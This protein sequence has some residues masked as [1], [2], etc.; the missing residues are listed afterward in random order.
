MPF[1][2]KRFAR[3]LLTLTL[4]SGLL[5]GLIG[6]SLIPAK[7]A[8]QRLPT[9]LDVVINEV[10]WA[11]TLSNSADEW[12]ELY[13]STAVDIPLSGWILKST[14]NTPNIALS[15]T[16]PAHG[17]YLLERTDDA[18]INDILAD[19][20]Y[21]GALSDTGEA[22]ELRDSGGNLIDLANQAAGAWPA[23]NAASRTSMERIDVISDMPSSWLSND[24]VTRNG[25]DASG[26]SINGT[27]KQINSATVNLLLT[28]TFT[29]SPTATLTGTPTYTGTPTNTF[30]PTLTGTPTNTFTPTLS[31][32]STLTFTPVT[33]TV[34]KTPTFTNTPVIPHVIIS[35]VAWGGT[36]ASD[37]DEWIELYNPTSAAVNLNNW[38]V[39]ASDGLPL[40]PLSGTIPAGG[41]YLIERGDDNVVKDVTADLVYSFDQLSDAGETLSLLSDVRAVID[42]ANQSGTAWPAGGNSGQY[43]TMERVASGGVVQSDSIFAWVTNTGVVKNGHDAANHVIYGTPKQPNWAFTVTLTPTPTVSLTPT[44]TPTRTITPTGTIATATPTH[45]PTLGIIINEVAW[46]GTLASSSDEWIEL[47]NRGSA[48]VDMNGWTLKSTDGAISITITGSLPAN[49]YYILAPASTFTDVVIDQNISATFSND[50]KS[51]ELRNAAGILIDT[52][53][54]DGGAWPAGIASPTY[55]T[56]ERHAGSTL[57][58]A[59]NWYTYAGTPTSSDPHD[60]SNNLVKGTPGKANWAITVTATPTK[61]VTPTRTATKKG[62]II[63]TP[64]ATVV[65]NEFMPRAGFDWNQDGKVDVFDEFIEVANLGPVD[66]NLNGWKLDDEAGKGSSVFTMPS[67]VLKP[68]ERILFY[69]SQTNILLSDGGDT[70]RLLNPNNVIKDAQTYPVVKVENQ[71]WC[72][73]PDIHGSWYSDCFPTPNQQNTRTGEVPE[74]VPGTGL[75][76]PLCLLPDTL[77][78]DF[79][80][81]ECFGFG[82]EMWQSMY[83]DVPGWLLDFWAPQNGSKWETFV[84]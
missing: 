56:M 20:I 16:I 70:V 1:P 66:V 35:E 44:R 78:D 36:Q 34:T 23:G 11:G 79:R 50:G 21:T 13:N 38:Q 48:A 8:P 74:A 76:T 12:I 59:A 3:G 60:R 42:T 27:P 63:V 19:K 28:A 17:Y 47:Y 75:E 51:L 73:L 64:S 10:A 83:W 61:T 30:T 2:L 53:N 45:T 5:S 68:G 81:A 32:T 49:D 18:T 40:V 39:V 41:F 14:D 43:P 46:M 80:T 9:L 31:P 77:P 25:Q 24:N 54:S 15:G 65:I 84:E 55:A 69:A 7:A 4:L 6:P 57:D 71:S 26:N 67:K 58:N 62:S 72:R 37:F 82:S 29:V 52:A 33:S 22:L